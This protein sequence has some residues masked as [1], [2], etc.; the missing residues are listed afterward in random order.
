MTSSSPTTTGSWWS[1]GEDAASVL[2]KARARA[3][4]EEV[5][6]E[7]LAAGELGLD[8]YGM[9]DGLA[10]AGLTYVDTSDDGPET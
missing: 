10:A 9:R 7:R 6:R 4:N 8:L 3:A 1:G 2:D 5:K